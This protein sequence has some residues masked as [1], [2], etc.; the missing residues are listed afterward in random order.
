MRLPMSLACR[1]DCPTARNGC[2]GLAGLSVTA[3]AEISGL[4]RAP[5]GELP[6]VMR[7]DSLLVTLA[8]A[9]LACAVGGDPF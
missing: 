1:L 7:C 2:T 4:R 5:S 8:L 6:V 9:R 3:R